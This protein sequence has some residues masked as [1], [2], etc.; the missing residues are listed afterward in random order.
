[1]TIPGSRIHKETEKINLDL[2]L[3]NFECF[4]WYLK[5]GLFHSKRRDPTL[6]GVGDHRQTW[7]TALD[8][9]LYHTWNL[10]ISP[11]FLFFFKIHQS[12]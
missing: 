3:L 6:L 9:L 5:I 2:S 7:N 12:I 1:M 10:D 4:M 11:E 8:V